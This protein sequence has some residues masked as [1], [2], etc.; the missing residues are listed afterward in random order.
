MGSTPVHTATRRRI[1]EVLVDQGLIDAAQLER[2][3]EI[4]KATAPGQ[5]RKRLGSVVIEAGFATERQVAEALA[6]A[7]NLQ[8]VDLGTIPISPDIVRL[9]PRA[10]AERSALLLL[11]RIGTKV[12]VATSDPTNIFAIDDVKL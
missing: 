3:L 8:V 6:E 12:T 4:Q 2:A 9:L 1:G 11:T 10:V 7:L 5:Q